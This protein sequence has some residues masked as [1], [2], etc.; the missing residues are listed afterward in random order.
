MWPMEDS[1]SPASNNDMLLL[2]LI[3][4]NCYLQLDVK[5]SK[6]KIPRR[7]TPNAVI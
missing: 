5:D 6:I 4:C 3:L 7:L 2:D 1:P